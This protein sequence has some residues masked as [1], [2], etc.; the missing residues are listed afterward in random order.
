MKQL[1]DTVPD[2][3]GNG[4]DK[5]TDK[6]EMPSHDDGLFEPQR[7]LCKP[8]TDPKLDEFNVLEVNSPSLILV[9]NIKDIR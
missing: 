1:L 4:E 5:E 6:K 7:H 9:S 2:V 3:F 8:Q